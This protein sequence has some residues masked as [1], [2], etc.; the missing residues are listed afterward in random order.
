MSRTDNSAG[1]Y[2]VNTAVTVDM[3]AGDIL[4]PHNSNASINIV[5]YTNITLK[6]QKIS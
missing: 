5:D 2:N 4:R 1:N 3:K 6:A